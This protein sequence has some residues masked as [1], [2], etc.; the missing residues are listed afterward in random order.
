MN[1]I[2]QEI[3]STF[4]NEFCYKDDIGAVCHCFNWRDRKSYDYR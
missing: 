1:F 3:K 4:E 2:L